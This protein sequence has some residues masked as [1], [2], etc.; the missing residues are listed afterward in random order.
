M[1]R[2]IFLQKED[3]Y[4]ALDRLRDAFLAAKDG[5]EVEEIIKG[6]LT[7]DEKLRIG[8]RIITAEYIKAGINVDQISR[9][10]K[11]G[12]NTIM[13]VARALE[14]NPKSF[15]LVE[16][17]RNTVEKEY[18]KRKHRST[19]GSQIVFKG[20]EYTGFKRKDVKR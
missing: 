14:E 15:E 18:S 3:I 20:K 12:R 16:R 2:Y 7:Q 11:V 9:T 4:E 13:R 8:R 5:S 17:R 19:G 6:I 10:L 1:R